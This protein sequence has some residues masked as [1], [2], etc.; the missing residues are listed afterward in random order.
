MKKFKKII[1]VL[2]AISLVCAFAACS[3]SNSNSDS[4]SDDSTAE[5]KDITVSL[6]WTP[7]TNHTGLYVAL[8]Q[9]YYK[10]AGLNVKIVQPPEDDAIAA[11]SSGQVQLAV[12]YQDLL[13][14]A[15]TSDTPMEVTA[16]AAIL[17]HN[18]SCIMSKKG[19][20]MDRPK[21]LEGKEYLTWQAPIELAM[22]KN[23]VEADGGDFSKVTQV[24]NVP[25]DEA[26]DVNENPSH[27]I[28]VY[29]GWGGI[30]AEV[31]NID[32]DT[33]FFKD[34]N[35]TF[36]YYSPVL[37]ANNDLIKNDPD[38]VKAFLAATQKGYEYA[39]ENPDEAAQMLIDGD[40]TGS[41]K[42][43]EELVKASQKY[44]ADQYISDAPKWGYIDPAR[45]NAFYNW[46]SEEKIVDK[47]IP[48]NTGFTNDY[49]A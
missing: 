2:L 1:A 11:C 5:L 30:N 7:N 13:A 29:Y 23:V 41:L 42:G 20:G 26:K 49:L 9:G 48:E 36:D 12:G 47:T 22:M 32:V 6:D 10:D 33:F 19:E 40:D 18:T 15:F 17:Q 21:G 34:L 39:V 45:W 25:T 43:S 27:A 3:K 44:M 37:V 8:Q 46:L 35:S 28:W 31:N 38:T 14:S 16:V 4:S 24:P